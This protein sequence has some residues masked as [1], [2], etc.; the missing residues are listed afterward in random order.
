MKPILSYIALLSLI[1]L[2]SISN[3]QTLKYNECDSDSVCSGRGVSYCCIKLRGYSNTTNEYIGANMC[4]PS[5]GSQGAVLAYEIMGYNNLTVS[6]WSAAS[7]IVYSGI[8][9][10][11]V[12]AWNLL[13]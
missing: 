6:C 1:C 2:V 7:M 3:S 12:L 10:T 8:V 9:S 11:A 4:G 5:G 13:F